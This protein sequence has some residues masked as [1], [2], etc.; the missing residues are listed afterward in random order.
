M[1]LLP[2]KCVWTLPLN[3]TCPP[4]IVY[5]LILVVI[6]CLLD[7]W[8]I[9]RPL[10]Q[11]QLIPFLRSFIR[12]VNR[13]SQT[14]WT[15]L[16]K[17]GRLERCFIDMGRGWDVTLT[18]WTYVLVATK[19]ECVH[20]ALT[21]SLASHLCG[22]DLFAVSSWRRRWGWIYVEIDSVQFEWNNDQE[23]NPL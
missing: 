12:L 7:S 8:I 22:V 11:R 19:D 6:V 16:T 14:I 15:R 1:Y 9:Q 5:F 21:W 17:F 2:G 13:L 18:W 4:L 10:V 3:H 23:Y 20:L